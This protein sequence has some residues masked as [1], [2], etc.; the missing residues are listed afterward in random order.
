MA[1]IKCP[2]CSHGVSTAA[3]ACPNCGYPLKKDR[4]AERDFR[5][6]MN[7]R[8]RTLFFVSIIAVIAGL[9]ILPFSLRFA[10]TPLCGGALALLVHLLTGTH[11]RL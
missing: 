6:W 10:I 2:E 9:V 1:I 4:P 5:T 11:K 8:N 7:E 3:D